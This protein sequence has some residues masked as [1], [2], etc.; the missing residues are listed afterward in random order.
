[1]ISSLELSRAPTNTYASPP[2]PRELQARLNAGRRIV[3]LQRAM[4]KAKGTD[5]LTQTYNRA[6]LDEQLPRELVR[7]VRFHSP[8]SVLMGRH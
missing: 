3:E 2:S 6:Y 8:L 1:M 7:A 5:S 4:R